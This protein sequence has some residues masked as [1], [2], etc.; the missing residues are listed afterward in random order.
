MSR[1]LIKVVILALLVA[2]IAGSGV[3]QKPA[4]NTVI[5]MMASLSGETGFKI[6]DDGLGPYV[7]QGTTTELNNLTIDTDGHF[8]M[9]VRA[10]SGR[11]LNLLFETQCLPPADPNPDDCPNPSYLLSSTAVGTT[12]WMLRTYW[13]CR[14]ISHAGDAEPWT[15]LIRSTTR[16]DSTILDLRAMAPGETVGVSVEGMR[17]CEAESGSECY[18]MTGTQWS[19]SAPGSAAYLLVTATDW[20]GD[21]AMD[22]IL[23]TIPGKVVIKSYD[24]TDILPDGECFRLSGSYPC[25]YGSFKLPFELKIAKVN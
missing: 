21:G 23:R 9:V 14:Y 19:A 18:L 5:P 3:A 2:G 4:R 8:L 13:K 15:E 1:T 12:Y 20:D 24:R 17:F 22:W 25:A 11:K 10:V 7:H 6:T 16:K